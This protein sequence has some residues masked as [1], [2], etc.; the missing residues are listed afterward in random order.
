MWSWIDYNVQSWGK[1]KVPDS[2]GFSGIT[3][4]VTLLVLD[5]AHIADVYVQNTP[6]IHDVNVQVTLQN[7]GPASVQGNLHIQVK[8][9]SDEAPTLVKQDLQGVTIPPGESVQ[10]VKISIPTAKLWD[11]DHPTLYNCSVSLERSGQA[12][13]SQDQ[14]FGFRWFAPEDIGTN[15]VFR[16]NGKRIVLRTA[17]SWGFWGTSGLVPT[18]KIAERQ[19][20]SAKA[21][22]LNMLN[23]HRAIGQELLMDDADKMGLLYFEEPGCYVDGGADPFCELLVREKLLRMVKRDRSHPSL[24]IYNMI[25]EQW[26]QYRADKVPKIYANF[27]SDMAAAHKI[28]PS[29][30][31]VLA[32]SWAKDGVEQPVKLNMMPFDDQQRYIGWKDTHRAG[33]PDCWRQ[34]FYQNPLQHYGFTADKSEIVYWGEEGAIS[35]PPRLELIKKE[36]AGL[37]APG[38]DGEIYLD[39][40]KQFDDYLTRKNLRSVFPTVDDL[41][42]ALGAVSIEHQGR[43]IEDTRICDLNDGYAIN[44]WECE[45]Y[46]NHSGIVDCFRN[47]KGDPK[48]LAYYNQPFYVAVKTRNEVVASGTNATVDYYL[49]NEKDVKGPHTL[50]VSAL[51]PD[52]TEAFTKD[53][54][55]TV[56]GGETYGQLLTEAVTIPT[57]SAVGLWTLKAKLIDANGQQA[58]EGHDQI[59]V[60][61]W[62]DTKLP[63]RGAIYESGSAI[64]NFLKTKMGLDVPAYTSDLGPLDW[65]LV[66]RSSGNQPSTVPTTALQTPDGSQPGLQASFF[67]GTNFTKKLSNRVD[68]QIEFS[69]PEGANPG[70]AVPAGSQFCARWEGK[71]V[72]PI[73]G[74]YT[75]ALT[76]VSGNATLKIDGKVILPDGVSLTANVPVSLSLDYVPR[77]GKSGVTLNWVAPTKLE[78]STALLSRAPKDGTTIILADNVD[79]WMDSVKAATQVSYNGIVKLGGNWV[80]GQ[81]FAIEH[82][83]FKDLPTNVALNWPYQALIDR[84]RNR[85]GLKLEGEQLVAGCWQSSPMALGTAVGIIPSG[86]GKI[87]VST[88]NICSHLN[89]PPGPA[90]VARKLLCNYIAFGAPSNQ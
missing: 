77:P 66:A 47:P 45:P 36:I 75:F 86:K 3:G 34:D 46:E 67:S 8:E 69:W 78:N 11:L 44:G 28:D 16:L 73:T 87:I 64:H 59:L 43:K 38:W 49:I 50:K 41:C 26:N 13:D 39:W 25:N 70:A 20:A 65:L 31:I 62:K 48:I 37:P 24:V 14:S 71:L 84:S 35:S 18:P 88:L 61:A 60:V 80:G 79:T 21:Y 63:G 54:P 52:G 2:R 58:A 9:K 90:D 89:D 74:T 10:T 51:T 7:D 53:F 5:P 29:R 22:G 1:V 23:F 82:P 42:L 19:I 76:T 12:L 81:C 55:V 17:I 32:S 40:Y 27:T 83:L 33:G 4:T 30:V 68:P 56:T 85:Y 15:A 57:T 6:A 72:P